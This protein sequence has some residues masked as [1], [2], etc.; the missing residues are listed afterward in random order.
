MHVDGGFGRARQD[1]TGEQ[2]AA[3]YSRPRVA[4]RQAVAGWHVL[5]LTGEWLASIR[6]YYGLGRPAPRLHLR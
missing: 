4:V 5:I 6:L 1:R 3:G 2:V